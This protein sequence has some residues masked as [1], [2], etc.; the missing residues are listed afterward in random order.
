MSTSPTSMISQFCAD[1]VS[2]HR[3][4]KIALMVGVDLLAL[5]FCFLIAMLLRVG[6]LSLAMHYGLAS[7]L[8]VALVTIA[9]FSLSDLYR[10]VIR[11]IDQRLLAATGL[12]LGLAVLCV[13]LVLLAINDEGFPRSA[14]AI[15]WFIVFSYVVTSRITVRNFLRNHIGE[16]PQPATRWPSTAPAKPGAQ[17]ALT[18]RTSNEYRPVCFFDD[19]HVLQRTH[20][21]RPARV[22][23]RP[24]GRNGQFAVHPLDHHRDPRCRRNAC[25]TS[26]SAWPRPA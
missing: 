23:H 25:A 4:A 2:M 9:A 26:C 21:R 16:P 8:V 24:P 14:L 20:H 19:K 7:Y 3:T 11:F 10:A 12:A 17:L 15:Y 6:D 22:P 1:M 13:Y 5:P 18:M